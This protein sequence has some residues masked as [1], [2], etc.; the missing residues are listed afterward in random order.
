MNSKR[1]AKARHRAWAERA[2]VWRHEPTLAHVREDEFTAD[3]MP[4]GEPLAA[5]SS[6]HCRVAPPL[7]G[8]APSPGPIFKQFRFSLVLVSLLALGLYGRDF[9]NR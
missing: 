1:S 4:Q 9:M 7:S 2:S 8:F 5:S 6:T 3:G